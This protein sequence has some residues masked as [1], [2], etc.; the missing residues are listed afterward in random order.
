MPIINVKI[1]FPKFENIELVFA[2]KKKKNPKLWVHL[3][4]VE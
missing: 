1:L 4:K 3:E 2:K